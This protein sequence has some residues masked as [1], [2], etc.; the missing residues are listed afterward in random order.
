[1]AVRLHASKTEITVTYGAIGSGGGI[2]QITS[3][4]VDFGA[5]DAPL[6]E[7]QFE[8]AEGRRADSR[9]P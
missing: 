9:G 3:R 1:M 7:E 4:T 5:S 2:D 6:T 8:E